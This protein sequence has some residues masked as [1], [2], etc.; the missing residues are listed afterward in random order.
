MWCL[1]RTHNVESKELRTLAFPLKG[2]ENL[3]KAINHSKLLP[4]PEL[5][6]T[7]LGTQNCYEDS[8]Y[9]TVVHKLKSL[10]TGEVSKPKQP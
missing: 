10:S 3:G 4:H 9:V 6:I 5:K 2:C 1:K 7:L 8:T